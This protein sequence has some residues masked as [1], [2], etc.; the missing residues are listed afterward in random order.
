MPAAIE[1][2]LLF[3]VI[4]FF[5]FNFIKQ[6]TLIFYQRL[7]YSDRARNRLPAR[8]KFVGVQAR[9]SSGKA[10]LEGVAYPLVAVIESGSY[11]GATS[12]RYCS[13]GRG[14]F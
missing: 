13:P 14:L 4:Y 12:V 11:L 2:L 6:R 10:R 1:E 5:G 9:G 3:F 8:K 7:P